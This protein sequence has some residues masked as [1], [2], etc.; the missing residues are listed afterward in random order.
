MKTYATLSLL[1]FALVFTS[2][3]ETKKVIDVAGSVQLTGSYTV[4]AINGEKV[5]LKTHPIFSLSALDN[6]INA[7]SGCNSIF[8]KYT[9]DLYA[10]SFKDLAVTA[11]ECMDGNVMKVERTFIDALNNT[12]SYS[13]ENNLLTF[14]SKTDRSVILKATKAQKN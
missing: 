6:S 1:L 12:G 10:I 8:G 14:Y 13:L 4:F 9:L 5:S 7:D 3:D 2:C 11:K